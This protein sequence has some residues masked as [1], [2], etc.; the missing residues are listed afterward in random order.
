[1]YRS[2]HLLAC[3]SLSAGL[4]SADPVITEF[5]A[6]NQ[7]SISD[8]D[9]FKADWI[10]IHNPDATAVEMEGWSLTDNA[11]QLRK[12]VFP[13]VSIPPKGFIIVFA[14]SKNRGGNGQPLH[15]NFALS[16]GGEYL[17]LVKPDGTTRT[18]EFAPAFPAQFGDISYGTAASVSEQTVIELGSTVKAKVPPNGADGTSW[19][20]L[21]FDDGAWSAGTLAAGYYNF[22][23]SSAINLTPML[24]LDLSSQM[25]GVATSAYLRVPFSVP[26]AALVTSVKLRMNYDDGF[27]AFINGT[28]VASS[29]SAPPVGSLVFNSGA[30]TQHSPLEDE[31]DYEEVDASAAIGQLV[32][33][34]NILAIHGLNAGTTSSDFH[35]EPQLI[36]TTSTGGGGEIGYFATA[37]PGAPN[38]GPETLQLP[39]TIAYSR[40]SGPFTGSFSLGITGAA[41]G[42][43]IRYVMTNPGGAFNADVPAPTLT[44]T[45]YT[46][47]ITVNSSKIIRAAVFNPANGQGGVPKTAQYLL[48]ETGPGNNTSSFTS[49]LPIAVIDHH[50]GGGY[51]PDEPYKT[52]FLHF[53]NR[54]PAGTATLNST[55]DVFTRI[56]QKVRGSSSAH[57][58]KRAY[59]MKTRNDQGENEKFELAGLARAN[60]WVWYNPWKYDDAYVRNAFMFQLSRDM[61]HWASRTQPTEMFLNVNGGKLDYND[62]W[63]IYVLT[64]KIESGKDRLDIE[65][66][67]SADIAGD[68]LTGGYILKIDRADADETAWQTPTAQAGSEDKIVVVEP[69]QEDEKP[70]QIA[71]IQ[72]YIAGFESAVLADR[73]GNWATRNYQKYIDVPSW[74]DVHMLHSFA[75]NPDSFRLSSYFHKDRNQKLKAGPIWDFDRGLNAD[76]DSG[77]QYDPRQWNGTH[78]DMSWWKQVWRDP[79]F[80]QAWVDRWWELR[81]GALSDANLNQIITTM[82]NEIGNVAGARDV[83]KWPDN[84]P[85]AGTYLGEIGVLRDWLTSA[86]PGVLGRTHWIDLQVPGPPTASLQTA[87]VDAGTSVT[88]G[89]AQGGET[90]RYRINNGDPR[91][92]G[93]A[94]S[95]AP[96]YG[97]PLVINQTT[98]LKARRRSSNGNEFTP[99]PHDLNTR[100]SAPLTRVYLVNEDFATAADLTV[101]EIY[102]NPSG[103]QGAESG[104]GLEI[105]SGD[106]EFIELRNTGSRTVNTYGIRFVEGAPFKELSLEPLT[107]APGEFALVVK[108]KAAFL[109]R[110]GQGLAGRIAGEWREGSLANDAERVLLLARDGSPIHDAIYDDIA[111]G[112]FSLV[113]SGGGWKKDVPSPGA[114]GPTYQQWKDFH[115]P[116]G[117]PAAGDDEDGD[118]DGAGNFL[119]YSRGT[120]PAVVENQLAF[121]P[122]LTLVNDGTESRYTFTRPL[123]RPGT[124]YQP[125]VSTDLIDWSDVGSTPVSTSG[126]VETREVV[127]PVGGEEPSARFLRLKTVAV[128]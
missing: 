76:V 118:G 4:S 42:Q 126:G 80:I 35:I 7:D 22:N 54:G 23:G 20:Q 63:G 6:S 113:H 24:G 94:N 26:N 83:A 84:S 34:T 128:P 103:P 52:S 38:G 53:F 31:N 5:M 114:T 99:F 71:Y 1:M 13:A 21:A 111:N 67:G 33:G 17:A 109:A 15:T 115:F 61:G 32:D 58:P 11:S 107:L 28:H 79:E 3:L 121:S 41:S 14:S 127:L 104:A 102:Y 112:G 88:L 119:E 91:P 66:I 122:V 60:N 40:A 56:S 12:W 37:T 50:G 78:F 108:N 16:A 65:S 59:G 36:V 82:G 89:G 73:A 47:P 39:Q 70:E 97:A 46:G 49:P 125:Q 110:F 120:D 68:N 77:S 45:L 8:E 92:L 18:T 100:W 86:D 90:I 57:F 55:P 75:L 123:D 44:S 117:G 95:T 98:V 10:E 69:E 27:A 29:V 25:G 101:S 124:T 81:G 93:G 30:T 106:F 9:G 72:N 48:L 19:R 85:E 87:K 62:Y 105:T 2:I 74:I 116:G 51:G 43:E 64:E 96:S